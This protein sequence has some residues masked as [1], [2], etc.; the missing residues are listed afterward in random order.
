MIMSPASEM[1]RRD[2]AEPQPDEQLERA[3]ELAS[4]LERRRGERHVVALQDYPD[5]D[6]I[7]SGLAYREMARCFGVSVDL[8]YD[9]QISHPENLALVN[10]LELDV[11]RFHDELDLS[12]YDAA[13]FVDNQGSTTRLTGR[14]RGAGVPTF[15]VI[16]HH[17]PQDILEPEF[18]DVRPL[19]AAVSMMVE[20]LRSGE[21]VELDPTKGAHMQLATAL[22]HG[23]H[24][25]T[26]GFIHAGRAEYEAAA[27]LS[28][29]IDVDL[30]ERVLCVQ[31]SRGTMDVTQAALS[32][33]CIRG[34]F[35]VA[36]V[37]AVRWA[38]RDA[39]PQAADFLLT[40][41]NVHTAVVYGMVRTEEGQELISGSLRTSNPTLGVDAFLKRALGTDRSGT[42]LGGGRSRAGGFEIEL[43]FLSG[44]ADERSDLKWKLYDRQISDK[45]FRAAGLDESAE[46][47]KNA[48]PPP[49]PDA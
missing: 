33:R 5:P 39:I 11:V 48:A 45:L 35:S 21:L 9:G 42:P 41:E 40:E 2:E 31:K 12:A 49:V 37:G 18:H 24:A 43:G 27:Y 14:L 34:G 6:A 7:A 20:Y 13:V 3:R 32:Q 19:G 44:G 15:A 8:I 23:L 36:G 16:D 46:E 29:F 30:L 17:D 10:L 22:M 47:D 25:E 1:T 38:D 28:R 26:D 4:Q